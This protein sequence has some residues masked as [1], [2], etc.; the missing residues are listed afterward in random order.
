MQIDRL[1][2]YITDGK[3]DRRCPRRIRDQGAVPIVS[4]CVVLP[5][6]VSLYMLKQPAPAGEAVPFCAG[7]VSTVPLQVKFIC[8]TVKGE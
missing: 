2:H 5:A 8:V 3:A 7:G 6:T 1:A 4:P